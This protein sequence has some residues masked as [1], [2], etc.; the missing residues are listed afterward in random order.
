M[1]KIK[2]LTV[3]SEDQEILKDINLDVNPGEIHAILGQPRSGKSALAM[4]VSGL[5]YVKIASGS[6]QYKNK[7]LTSM[8]M[9]DRSRNGIS[10]IFQQP[11][12]IPNSTNWELLEYILKC[13]KDERNLSD[14]KEYYQTLIEDLQLTPHHGDLIADGDSMTWGEAMRNELLMTFMLDPALTIIDDIDEKLDPE[15]T[16]IVALNIK[17]WSHSKR[18]ATIVLSKDKNVLELIEP[19]HVH[20]LVNGKIVLSGGADLLQRIDK[21]GYPELSTSRKG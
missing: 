15:E 13:R 16:A 10:T 14:L 4:V 21:D 6:I 20:V 9:E 7:K 12:E 5:P 19:T 8:S 17:N 18:R 2:Q 3:A 1:L 11:V